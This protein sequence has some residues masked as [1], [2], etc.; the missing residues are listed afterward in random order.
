[1]NFNFL[2]STFYFL[3]L[4][5]LTELPTRLTSTNIQD[6][7]YNFLDPYIDIILPHRVGRGGEYV[8]STEDTNLIGNVQVLYI[9]DLLCSANA[10]TGKQNRLRNM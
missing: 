2:L 10:S 1:M 7:P 5:K 6:L 8:Y 3:L 9:P 4:S